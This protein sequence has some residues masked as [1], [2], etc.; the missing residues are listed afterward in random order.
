LKLGREAELDC[1][2]QALG[3]YPKDNGKPLMDFSKEIVWSDLYFRKIYSIRN[4][5][6][7]VKLDVEYGMFA[8]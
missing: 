3:L 5:L 6:K 8:G 1:K 7:G 4:L 2:G